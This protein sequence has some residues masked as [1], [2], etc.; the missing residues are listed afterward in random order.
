FQDLIEF[1]EGKLENFDAVIAT[2]SNNTARYF[3]HYFSKKP[4]IIRKNRTSIAV[5]DGSESQGDLKLLGNDIFRYFGLGCRNI[6]KLYIPEN[7]DFD[8]FFKAVFNWKDLIN[9]SKY[10]NNYDYNK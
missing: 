10:A 2:G 1:T 8:Q 5:L 4:N 3:E 9:H 6:S 7:Y